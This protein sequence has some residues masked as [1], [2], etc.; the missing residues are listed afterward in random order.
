MFVPFMN[1]LWQ[2]FSWTA[3]LIIGF[4]QSAAAQSL[5]SD[6]VRSMQEWLKRY[7]VYG[8][9]TDGRINDSLIAF[10][11]NY[12][13][14]DVLEESDWRNLLEVRDVARSQFMNIRL[15]ALHQSEVI[16]INTGS[17]ASW[18]SKISTMKSNDV[19]ARSGFKVITDDK[20]GELFLSTFVKGA[21]P[22]SIFDKSI[23]RMRFILY[24]PISDIGLISI[25]DL[26]EPNFDNYRIEKGVF[27]P[28]YIIRNFS[29]NDYIAWGS[30]GDYMSFIV[31]RTKI[32]AKYIKDDGFL[33]GTQIM[34]IIERGLE[35]A[36]GSDTERQ[37]VEAGA[38]LLNNRKMKCGQWVTTQAST[39]NSTWKA[40]NVPNN[41]PELSA[42]R[43]LA[44]LVQTG[45]A[46]D[47][48]GNVNAI[49]S[50]ADA[51][52]IIVTIQA[53]NNSGKCEITG[54]FAT[55]L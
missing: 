23:N 19:F 10:G 41:I 8:G 34:N 44:N 46:F 30:R 1:R 39:I 51:P 11:R 47:A 21:F 43:L 22:Y 29:N 55:V 40:L 54:L 18:F 32:T 15:T 25:V 9:P 3:V 20:R 36:I 28:G 45:G 42:E 27:V 52:N 13:K 31:S 2:A 50:P 38:F 17:Y 7:G 26:S 49:F 33:S 16:H 35:P 48:D 37:L 6:D 5:S 4:S 24:N 12:L 14:K 53:R